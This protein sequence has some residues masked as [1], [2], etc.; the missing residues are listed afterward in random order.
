ML[1]TESNSSVAIAN[2]S[3]LANFVR[4]PFAVASDLVELSKPGILVLLLISTVCPMFVAAGGSPDLTLVFFTLLGGGLVSASASTLN[5]IWDMDIDAIMERTKNRALPA[6]RLKPGSAMLFSL[7]TGMGG[8]GVLFFYVNPAAAFLSLLGH[9]FYVLIY[10]AWL[11]RTTAQNI[12]IGGAA[13]AVP[14]L[15]GWAAVTGT[16]SLES[17][18][19]FAVIFLW[20]PPHF[21]ALAINKNSDYR[22][23]RVPMMPVAFGESTTAYQM[24]IYALALIP[25][26]VWL[27]LE[28]PELGS[29]SMS[30]LTVLAVY[31]CW[32]VYRL[33]R[34]VSM[35]NDNNSAENLEIKEK[36]AWSVFKFSLIYLAL[37][38]VAMVVDSTLV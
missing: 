31:F 33:D 1:E 30:A 24:F 34:A 28:N 9:L 11:K 37:F 35:V 29:F 26:S 6:G 15:V 19:M 3:S 4:K 10:T 23:A 21:W 8:I 2:G 36:R 25:A 18:L 13:G 27:V 12:V 16:I 38:F 20:T 14:P 7:V 5:C 32:T 22:K 17:V